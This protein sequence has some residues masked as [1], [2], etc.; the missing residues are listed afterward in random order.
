MNYCIVHDIIYGW[1]STESDAWRDALR[2][3]GVGAYELELCDKSD[4]LRCYPLSDAAFIECE[5]ESAMGTFGGS[6]MTER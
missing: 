6:G 2:Q 5:K 3:A 1:G 4:D